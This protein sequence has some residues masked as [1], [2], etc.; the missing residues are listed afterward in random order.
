MPFRVSDAFAAAADVVTSTFG[1][2]N[3]F[4][5][6]IPLKYWP[7]G[8]LSLPAIEW[9]PVMGEKRFEPVFDDETRTTSVKEL[10]SADIRTPD[11]VASGVDGFQSDAVIEWNGERWSLDEAN[12]AWDSEFVTFGLM[13][14]PLTHMNELRRAPV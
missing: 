12:S 8:N 2:S 5:D 9:R 13:R 6:V 14:E 7:P 10:W 1:E 3:E 11:V 4:G